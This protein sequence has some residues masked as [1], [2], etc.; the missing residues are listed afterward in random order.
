MDPIRIRRVPRSIARGEAGP[1]CL[2]VSAAMALVL[3]ALALAQP[4]D[5][6]PPAFILARDYAVKAPHS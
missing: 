1:L 4:R 3:I 6:T 5:D 2:L